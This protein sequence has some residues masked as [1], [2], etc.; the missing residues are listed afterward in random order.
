MRRMKCSR[1]SWLASSPRSRI[2]A[3]V[4]L[5]ARSDDGDED[6]AAEAELARQFAA[7]QQQRA[8]EQPPGKSV[9]A[10]DYEFSPMKT[11]VD[12]TPSE[13]VLR[14]AGSACPAVSAAG[15]SRPA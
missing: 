7:T 10:A 2:S 12:D 1:M 14:R 4:K 9:L 13:P 15:P 6:D 11:L 3:M 8:G 5:S